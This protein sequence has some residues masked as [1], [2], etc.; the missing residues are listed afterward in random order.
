MR[1]ILI[2]LYLWAI[3]KNKLHLGDFSKINKG[4][5]VTLKKNRIMCLKSFIIW[6]E[7]KA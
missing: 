7:E 6:K 4:E 5:M 2:C 1:K 3:K